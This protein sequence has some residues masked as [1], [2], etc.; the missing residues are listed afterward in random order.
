M[1]AFFKFMRNFKNNLVQRILGHN[2]RILG[3]EVEYT[4]KTGGS[5]KVQVIFDNE[6]QQV[7]PDTERLISTNQPV[8][9]VRLSDLSQEARVGDKVYVIAENTDYIVQDVQEDGQGGASLFL[10]RKKAKK[11]KQR[12]LD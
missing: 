10:K 6:W 3:E 9:G 7:D 11:Q 8:I 5:E 4:F 1:P 2:T 12:L